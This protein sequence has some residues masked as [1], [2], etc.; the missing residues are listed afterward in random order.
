MTDLLSWVVIIEE[1]RG[2]L[3]PL[4]FSLQ[5]VVLIIWYHGDH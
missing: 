3:L 1:Q 2:V 5:I 4:E